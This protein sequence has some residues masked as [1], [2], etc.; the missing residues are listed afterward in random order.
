M[1][2]SPCVPGLVAA[3]AALM[4]CGL[5]APARA[6]SPVIALR[7]NASIVRPG[8]C[9]RL[10]AL[11]LDYV[12]GPVSAQVTY[13][14]SAPVV[15]KKAD[16][17][18]STVTRASEVR[19]QSGPVIDALNRQQLHL[20]DDTFCF[21]QGGTPGP[22]NVE[23]ALRSGA[24]GSPFATLTTCVM[25]EDPDAP[26]AAAAQGCGFLVRGLKRA[27]TEDFLV[28]DADLPAGGFYRGAILR[29]GTV[30]AV[31][32]AGI[33]QTGTHELSVLMPAL[34]R[35]GGGTADLVLVDQF[36]KASSTVP[37]LPVP[38]VR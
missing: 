22:Y 7:A 31:L 8:D 27:D 3:L 2:T 33:T 36:G 14:Y 18:E 21:G 34:S 35:L 37:R 24:S 26:V 17:K 38:P 1:R 5:A 13:R 4:V 19:R 20:L 16:G 15:V 11:A 9:L 12:P 23:V 29:G 10:E 32:D 30:E 6:Q 28:F 25:F